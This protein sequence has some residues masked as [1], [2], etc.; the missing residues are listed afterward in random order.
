VELDGPTLA[1]DTILENRV[2]FGSVNAHRQDWLAAVEGRPR[3]GALARCARG[4]VG[5]RVP[6][7][8]FAEAFAAAAGDPRGVRHRSG[9]VADLLAPAGLPG[10]TI[11]SAPR[12]RGV[13]PKVAPYGPTSVS[14][15][16]D[17]SM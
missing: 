11:A 7:D 10:R 17:C 3:A 9:A 1:L 5:L 6:L 12:R 16:I 4:A 8:R 15:A 14:E 13:G 2:L